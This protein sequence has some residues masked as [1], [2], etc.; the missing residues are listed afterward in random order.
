MA[1]TFAPVP[2]APRE[3]ASVDVLRNFSAKREYMLAHHPT[4][5]SLHETADGYE[6]LPDVRRLFFTSGTN[7]ARFDHKSGAFINADDV[8]H[9]L[10]KKGFIIIPNDSAA[11]PYLGVLQLGGGVQ[12]H[13]FLWEQ[14]ESHPGLRRPHVVI[15]QEHRSN[16]LRALYERGVV[17]HPPAAIRQQQIRQAMEEVDRIAAAPTSASQGARLKAAEARLEALQLTPM[18]GEADEAPKR[19]SR[20]AA[21]EDA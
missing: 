10:E 15:D 14:Y 19:R 6:W 8:K 11:G 2:A 7:G 16:F 21:K 13:C 9:R 17:P 20:K 18:P 1:K 5:W 4:N 12:H 3:Q